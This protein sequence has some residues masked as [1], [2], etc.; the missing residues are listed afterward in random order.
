MPWHAETDMQTHVETERAGWRCGS[1]THVGATRPRTRPRKARNLSAAPRAVSNDRSLPLSRRLCEPSR[2]GQVS[3]MTT[4][5]NSDWCLGSGE[6]KQAVTARPH[7]SV[8]YTMT[9]T[10]RGIAVQYEDQLGDRRRAVFEAF[11]L[12]YVESYGEPGV[13]AQE[14]LCGSALACPGQIILPCDPDFEVPEAWEDLRQWAAE[15]TRVSCS[16]GLL[17]VDSA[18]TVRNAMH[19]ALVLAAVGGILDA[20]DFD[21]VPKGA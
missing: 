3:A 2:F 11:R 15:D 9:D 19:A 8:H 10:A 12:R 14:S 17:V 7:G 4:I 6:V 13:F 20:L 5:A 1:D 21:V 16:A 18:S